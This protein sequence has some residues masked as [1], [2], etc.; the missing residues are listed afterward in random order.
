MPQ[1]QILIIFMLLFFFLI[2]LNNTITQ[3]ANKQAFMKQD[4][5]NC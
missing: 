2:N 4:E 3:S 1:I 5:Y